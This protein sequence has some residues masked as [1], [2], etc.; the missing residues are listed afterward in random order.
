MR[1]QRCGGLLIRANFGELRDE[2]GHMCLATRCVN[3]GSIEDSV[4]R[5]NRLRR[6]GKA[7][8]SSGDRQN[9]RSPAPA[10]LLLKGRGP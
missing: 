2:I 3:C 7:V 8:D 9:W 10:T 1:C 6:P 5:A 4:V